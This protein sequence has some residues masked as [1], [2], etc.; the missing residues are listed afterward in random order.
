MYLNI[1][2]PPNLMTEQQVPRRGGVK[3]WLQLLRTLSYGSVKKQIYN[4][5]FN[6]RLHRLLLILLQVCWLVVKKK[7]KVF[8]F[9]C[10]GGLFFLLF[11]V[12][13]KDVSRLFTFVF[14]TRFTILVVKNSLYF[15]FT[16]YFLPHNKEIIAIIIKFQEG[17]LLTSIFVNS[18]IRP[19]FCS[20]PRCVL[21]RCSHMEQG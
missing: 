6:P 17:Q 19:Y 7:G 8:Y 13:S 14:V 2:G 5:I 16:F 1:Y 15:N 18:R 21:W 3:P 9:V 20:Y 10:L 11:A 12:V 4:H